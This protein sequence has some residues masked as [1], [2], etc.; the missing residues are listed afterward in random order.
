M[1][2]AHVP[3]THMVCHINEVKKRENGGRDPEMGEERGRGGRRDQI[4]SGVWVPVPALLRE[5]RHHVCTCTKTKTRINNCNYI[6][7][8]SFCAVVGNGN[9]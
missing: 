1:Y 4:E 2:H 8:K 6:K 3:L 7:F 5:R 9:N